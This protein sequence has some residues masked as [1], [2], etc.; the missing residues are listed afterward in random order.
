MSKMPAF[1]ERM[2]AGERLFLPNAT[3]EDVR[4][5]SPLYNRVKARGQFIHF[6][7]GEQD[8]VTGLFAWVDGESGRGRYTN[9]GDRG[10]RLNE[11]AV[12]ASD[13]IEDLQ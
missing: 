12:A 1:V 5:A 8:G 3:H 11:I 6:R 2:L 7:Q 4:A 9:S 10:L 13:E